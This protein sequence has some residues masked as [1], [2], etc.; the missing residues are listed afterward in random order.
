MDQVAAQMQQTKN[1]VGKGR[2]VASPADG[3][4]LGPNS[5][6]RHNLRKVCTEPLGRM[7]CCALKA[8][9][10]GGSSV[11]TAMSGR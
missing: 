4:V 1:R 8:S 2:V 10:C 7:S 9:S 11:G 5:T 3:R 6:R